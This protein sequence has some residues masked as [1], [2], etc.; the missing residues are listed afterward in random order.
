MA[1]I[2]IRICGVL[3]TLLLAT[4]A[5]AQ[6]G[7]ASAGYFPPGYSGDTWSGTVTSVNAESREITLTYKG[8]DRDE[9]FTGVLRAGYTRTGKDGKPFE[10]QMAQIPVG[11]YMVAY[12]MPKSKKVEGQKTKYFEIFNFD[13]Y[14]TAPKK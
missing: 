4:C 13:L 14:P 11:S 3:V 1:G 9:T 10:V 5:A 6:H 2:K 7:T 12:Y 8:K